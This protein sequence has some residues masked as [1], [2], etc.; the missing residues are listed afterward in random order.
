M[1][2]LLVAVNDCHH[3]RELLRFKAVVG[4]YHNES[5]PISKVQMIATLYFPELER[6]VLKYRIVHIAFVAQTRRL[7]TILNTEDDLSV[8]ADLLEN[9]NEYSS[10]CEVDLVPSPR[11]WKRQPVRFWWRS[12][13]L[14]S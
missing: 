11:N 12:S 13:V 14:K 4:E 7:I 8:K 5:D 1:E 9:Y 6:E 3:F 2:E 10:K